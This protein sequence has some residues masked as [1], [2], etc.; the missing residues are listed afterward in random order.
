[1]LDLVIA[2]LPVFNEIDPH[3]RM[4]LIERHVIDKAK[5]MDNPCGAVVS[6]IIGDTSGVL[7]RLHLTEQKGMI[8]FFDTKNIVKTMRLQSLDVRG[9]GTQTV[10]GDNELEVGVVLAQLGNQAFGGITLTIVFLS[11]PW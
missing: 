4:R 5:A 2:N 6:L 10:F 1:M 3:V 7:R 8:A 9:I 11:F